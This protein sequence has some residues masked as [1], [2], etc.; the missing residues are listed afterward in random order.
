MASHRYIIGRPPSC[1]DPLGDRV[2]AE[3]LGQR[4]E[5][6]ST[7][8]EPAGWDQALRELDQDHADADQSSSQADQ[9]AS[10][11]DQTAS[12]AAEAAVYSEQHRADLEQLASDLDQ[13][14]AD[15]DCAGSR[16]S[17]ASREAYAASKLDRVDATAARELSATGR[18]S[19][20]AVR[21][22]EDQ[23]RGE[24]ARQRDATAGS[25][26][27]ASAAR[28]AASARSE[29]TPTTGGF[30]PGRSPGDHVRGL[31][32]DRR[33]CAAGDRRRAAG[34]RDYAAGGALSRGR[35]TVML[36]DSSGAPR[37]LQIR[38]RFV[39]RDA[40]QRALERDEFSLHYQPVYDLRTGRVRAFEALL[41]WTHPELGLIPPDEFIPLAEATGVI[42]PIGQWVIDTALASVGH[43]LHET[44]RHDL[45]IAVNV[46]PEQL[47]Q[48][49]F[50]DCIAESLAASG[51]PST[52]L[53]LEI[54]ERTLVDD[55]PTARA[56][57][58]RLK[59]LGIALS[60][61][62]FGTG[63]SSLGR[64]S[65]FPVDELKVDRMFV[66]EIA[67]DH[68]QRALVAGIVAMATALKMRVVAEGIETEE[69][70]SILS[71]VGCHFGQGYLLARPMIASGVDALL[72]AAPPQWSTSGS[73]ALT[74]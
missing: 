53:T 55:E 14:A 22:R 30:P 68:R 7:G 72:A 29:Q 35:Q 24:A 44:N 49:D 26:D 4:A 74:P 25:R 1:D 39:L 67:V 37:A 59:D 27:D 16:V 71:D 56:S 2:A 19:A 61:D 11:A 60:V 52:A 65:S 9:N 20:E 40:L 10:D 64:L 13:A 46:A 31:A 3:P 12:D 48:R 43:W 32:A 54:T 15:R 18:A 57:M 73:P 34:A 42:V 21:T 50:S 63:F 70:R 33:A 47:L 62:D 69:Q 38:R 5:V 28:D 6:L 36:A 45:S 58:N 23:R 41:R 8:R 66:A 51:L 17:A